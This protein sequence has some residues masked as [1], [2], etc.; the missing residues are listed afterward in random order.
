MN[1]NRPVFT[2]S[3]INQYIKA[4]LNNDENLK[5]IYVKGEISNFKMASN[6]HF[7]FS[8][9]SRVQAELGQRPL[10]PFDRQ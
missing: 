3:D 9:I 1:E 8:L 6:G 7:Y 5:F 10:L 4:L 2:V